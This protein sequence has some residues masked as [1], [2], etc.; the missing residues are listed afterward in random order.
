MN[1]SSE[2]M[3]KESEIPMGRLKEV[4]N[5]YSNLYSFLRRV[6]L[7]YKLPWGKHSKE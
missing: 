4:H 2:E 5:T 7:L 3:K 1:P 6:E